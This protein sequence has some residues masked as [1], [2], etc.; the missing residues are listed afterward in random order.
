MREA[1]RP[2]EPTTIRRDP[3]FERLPFTL[4]SRFPEFGL[5]N[6]GLCHRKFGLVTGDGAVA[7]IPE[8]VEDAA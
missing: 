2:V 6:T 1:M 5:S 8:L 7:A 3:T 4:A